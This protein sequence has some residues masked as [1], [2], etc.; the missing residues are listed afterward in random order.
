MTDKTEHRITSKLWRL[1]GWAGFWL[2]LLGIVCGLTTFAVLT[3]LTPITPSD[4][5]I[6][7]LLLANLVLFA[8]LGIMIGVQIFFLLL[9]RRRGTPGA[10]LHIR[11]ISLFSLIAIVPAIIVAVF[12]VVTL[13]R[14]LDAWFSV[15]TQA[16][17]NSAVTVAEEY[18]TNNAQA[19]RADVAN[20]SADL[21][22]QKVLFDTDRAGLCAAGGATRGACGASRELSYLTRNKNG[23]T[24]MSQPTT[25]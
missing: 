9:E 8:I 21:N 2:V 18:I 17:V 4:K 16:I 22:Q 12:A 24:S 14:G 6:K 25:K 11:L 15:R 5:V 19:T 1:T 7:A 23:S 13:N 10:S 3:G 20:I